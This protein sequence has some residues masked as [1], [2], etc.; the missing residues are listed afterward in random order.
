[1]KDLNMYKFLKIV[2]CNCLRPCVTLP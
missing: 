2:S 1:M